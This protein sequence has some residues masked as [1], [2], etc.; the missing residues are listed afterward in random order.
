MSF[1]GKRA[2]VAM[3]H[4]G[5]NV[6]AD[7]F[8]N[9]AMTGANGGLLV[10]AADDP[11][12]HSSQN[13]QD[14]R[15]YARFAMVPCLEPSTQQE[16]YD[17]AAYGFEL[18]EKLRIPVL[19][20]TLQAL[21]ASPYI[22][23]ITVVTRRDKLLE[24]GSLCRGACLPKVTQVIVGGDSRLESVYKGI[25]QLSDKVKL[26][27]VHDAARCLV[28]RA[29][30]D[31][32]VLTAARCNAAVPAVAVKDTVKTF[33]GEF[34]TSTPDRETLR[35]VQTPQVFR[36]ELLRA[37]LQK[38]MEE[39]WEVTDDSSAV[40]RLGATVPLTPGDE[41]NIKITTPIDLAVAE[42]ILREDAP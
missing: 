17:M 6:A 37:A 28:P 33:D 32:A 41:R 3:K 24:V 1:C 5:M 10:V 15:F 40:E 7:G 21:S 34:I 36:A 26:I 25:H 31:A 9:S 18:S 20:R 38:A 42:A 39:G 11:S 4:V 13:E 30:I 8:V 14:S 2:I 35:A 19:V 23:E 22:H 16:A 29:V 27:A 12:M